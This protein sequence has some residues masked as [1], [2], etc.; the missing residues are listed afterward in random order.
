[1]V[2][3]A[4]T[5]PVPLSW[6]PAGPWGRTEQFGGGTGGLLLPLLE[7]GLREEEEEKGGRL[8]E[9][10]QRCPAGCSSK[11]GSAAPG[12]EEGIGFQE[13]ALGVDA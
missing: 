5:A 11:P 7:P 9:R 3:I 6:H 13:Q 12:A 4:V 8:E 1:M 2:Y 10:S